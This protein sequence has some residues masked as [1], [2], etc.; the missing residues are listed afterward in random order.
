VALLQ[1][2]VRINQLLNVLR[3]FAILVI[4]ARTSL[5]NDSIS[6][7]AKWFVYVSYA[8]DCLSYLICLDWSPFTDSRDYSLADISTCAFYANFS[9]SASGSWALAFFNF[10]F[11]SSIIDSS[12]ARYDVACII[13]KL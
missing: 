8:I 10:T 11:K 7:V 12:C 1:L 4:Q 3:R 2:R 6:S 5:R 13:S 9:W